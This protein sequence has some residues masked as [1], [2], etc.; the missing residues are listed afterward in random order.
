MRNK[1]PF[2]EDQGQVTQQVSGP[3]YKLGGTI[4]VKSAPAA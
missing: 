1:V 2:F 4:P 3:R